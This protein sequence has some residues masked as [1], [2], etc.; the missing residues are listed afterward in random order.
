MMNP[1]LAGFVK[2]ELSQA[3]RDPRMRAMLFIMPII[4]L[5]V[6][7]VAISSEVRNVRL[8]VR[9]RPDD[10][11]TRRL[12][13]RFYAENWFIPAPGCRQEAFDAVRSGCAE[14]ALVAPA[15]GA[16]TAMARGQAGYQLLI[17]ASNAVRARG[18]E[19]YARQVLA[20]HLRSEGLAP[21]RSG[22]AFSVR[23]LYNPE[24]DTAIYMIPGTLCLMLCLVTVILTSMSM[25]REREMGTL[26]TLLA[27]P[28]APWEVLLG[29]TVPYAL[30]GMVDLPL[31]LLVAHLLGVPIRGPLWLI[32]LST[33]VFVCA[34][35]SCGFLVSSYSGS[36]QQAMLGGFL[37]MF[38][39][40]QLSGVIYPVENMPAPIA[41]VARLNPLRYFVVIIRHLLLK[42]ADLGALLPNIAAMAAIG[43]VAMF[44]AARRF[45][46]T[47]N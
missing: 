7:G 30:L 4:Q 39:S 9:A 1:T 17:D 29:K 13:Q 5:V 35:V 45:R 12:A 23:T 11:F 37:F 15:E 38:P 36:Q 22:L 31:V 34:T 47:L 2:K 14:A 27:A 16:E 3:L 21:A 26:E 43:A 42:G 8:A 33:A 46:E 41:A 40:I 28:V 20:E 25:A 24:D 32:T 19:G 44:W 18:I 10:A 6:F